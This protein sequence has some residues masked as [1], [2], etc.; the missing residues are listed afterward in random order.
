MPP[1][2]KPTNC[3]T[4]VYGIQDA[5]T[6][7]AERKIPLNWE[8]RSF[9]RAQPPTEANEESSV[10]LAKTMILVVEHDPEVLDR[11]REILNHD[12]QVFLASTAKKAFDMVKKL[13][14]SVIL[15]DLDL[16]GDAYALI[17]ELHRTYPDLLIIAI[18]SQMKAPALQATKQL[19]VVEILWKPITPEWK[20][21]VERIRAMRFSG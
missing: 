10:T 4:R 8:C 16:P 11:A 12:R 7:N 1:L 3:A 21:V 17:G 20:P 15:V 5:G 18:G 19:G 9:L 13:G 6:S 2:N 14:F